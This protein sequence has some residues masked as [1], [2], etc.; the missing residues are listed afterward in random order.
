MLPAVCAWPP[1]RAQGAD[2]DR[3]E[4]SP[5]S[6]GGR[7]APSVKGTSTR[8]QGILD[9]L[10]GFMR[11]ER[12]DALVLTKPGSVA[13]A[14]GHVVAIETGP[15]VFAGGPTTALIAAK[16][17]AAVV[18][19][20]ADAA[21]P[22]SWARIFAY[23]GMGHERPT[24]SR[25][26]FEAALRAAVAALELGGR[27]GVEAT[28]SP[29]DPVIPVASVRDIEAGLNRLRAVKCAEEMPLLRRAAETACVGQNAFYRYL[30]IGRGE[31]EVFADIRR[32]MEM[33][34]GQRIAMAG[35]F[36]SGIAQTA[37]V[38]GWPTDRRIAAGD[39]VICDLSP[40]V[41]RYWGDSCASVMAGGAA[42]GYARYR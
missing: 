41:G 14:T 33:F 3:G 39:P 29:L 1:L 4:D 28:G 40:R 42:P 38:G 27:I 20:N 7:D 32:E 8:M 13:Y 15:S 22:T 2:V 12:L 19:I 16:G 26:N 11:E 30:E 36:V 35:D 10:T 37:R 6:G 21:N 25:A 5:S 18:C 31:L 24:D 34:A 17:D 23:E 9:R